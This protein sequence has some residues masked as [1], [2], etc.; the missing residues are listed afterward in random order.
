MGH[1]ALEAVASEFEVEHPA[2]P[3]EVAQGQWTP[4]EE[5]VQVNELVGL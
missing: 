4:V 5:E 2:E 1:L 3:V